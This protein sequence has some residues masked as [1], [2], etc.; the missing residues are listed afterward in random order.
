[1]APSFLL[2]LV[3]LVGCSDTDPKSDTA[4][5]ADTSTSDDSAD[6]SDTADSGNGDDTADTSEPCLAT[7]VAIDPADASLNVPIDGSI[8]ATLSAPAVEVSFTLDPAVEGTVEM[9]G[10][11]LS[12]SWTPSLPLARDTVYT[13]T[14]TVCE[15]SSSS[16]FTTVGGATEA[17]IVGRTYDV[18][19]DGRDIR[20]VKP[21]VGSLLVSQLVTKDFLFQV[22][23]ADATS[24]DL[25]GAVG[26]DSGTD[27][28]Q[29]PCA[30]ALDFDPGS[31]TSNP[32]FQV[33]PQDTSL[34]ASGVVVPV[35]GL[36]VDGSFSADAESMED[37]RLTG[38][39]DVS[40]LGD[41]LGG[42]DACTT[43]GLFGVACVACPGGGDTCVE[44]DV[45]DPSAP[46]R[47]G[48]EIDP[49]LLPDCR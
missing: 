14:I 42:G 6:T 4:T 31:F 48:V 32:Y 20:W 11:G 17:P 34:S 21:S 39:I 8:V 19:L 26:I 35:L 18:E 12:A 40:G 3:A 36:E 13:A 37:V 33:G 29:Y 7:V 5:D 27:V 1:L 41:A 16:T 45:R 49:M 28:V 25:V 22:Q 2:A 23:S 24:I 30:P 10:D 43:L 47:D 38:F 44:L 46:W 9:A 15:D